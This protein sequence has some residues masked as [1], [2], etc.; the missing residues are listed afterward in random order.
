MEWRSVAEDGVENLGRV[1]VAAFQLNGLGEELFEVCVIVLFALL[2]Q[3]DGEILA[4][5]VPAG[6]LIAVLLQQIPAFSEPRG[7]LGEVAAGL[8]Y[9]VA[10]GEE[11]LVADDVLVVYGWVFQRAPAQLG[12]STGRGRYAGATGSRPCG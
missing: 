6:A 11:N 10:E 9:I 12:Y 5:G 8:G 4:A 7:V 3:L 1:F 2:T